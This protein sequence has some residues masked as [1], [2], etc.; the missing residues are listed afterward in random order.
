M[1]KVRERKHPSEIRICPTCK[2]EFKAQHNKI[3]KGWDKYCSNI[4]AGQ[5]PARQKNVRSLN[6]RRDWSKWKP[7][8]QSFQKGHV[9]WNKGLKHSEET[10]DKIRKRRIQQQFLKHD[11]AIEKKVKNRLR[12][13]GVKF[14]EQYNMDNKFLIDIAFP[15]LK[16]AVECDG[17]YW[18]SLPRNKHVDKQKQI[19]CDKHGWQLLRFTD[20]QINRNLD[21]CINIILNEIKK[22]VVRL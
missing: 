18:H 8:P 21:D 20:K 5:S 15:T 3:M 4:C 17:E 9:P 10:I 6:D 1:G 12:E 11:T 19:H 16:I 13:W 14:E 2:K 22:G 7:M